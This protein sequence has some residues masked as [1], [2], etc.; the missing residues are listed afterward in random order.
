MIWADGTPEV[1][2]LFGVKISDYNY[3]YYTYGYYIGFVSNNKLFL[4]YYE[5]ST[6]G[7]S[8]QIYKENTE[9]L[10][11]YLK[12][13]NSYV[14][15]NIRNDKL[16]CHIMLNSEN[17]ETIMCFYVLIDGSNEYFGIGNFR[18]SSGSFL[19]NRYFCLG[20]IIALIIQ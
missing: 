3:G 1:F 7:N 5:Y 20:K 4:Q 13:G 14:D 6:Y 15:K 12:D 10:Q 2:S 17:K 11:C 9:G 8:T 18:I 16:S 19:V